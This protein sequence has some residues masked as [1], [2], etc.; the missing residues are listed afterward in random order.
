MSSCFRERDT[1]SK[2]SEMTS[3]SPPAAAQLGRFYLCVAAW[4]LAELPAG[5]AAVEPSAG[6]WPRLVMFYIVAPADVFD[7]LGGRWRN[8]R[9]FT[10]FACD[11]TF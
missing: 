5:E 2:G 10:A 11:A 8:A 7:G 1:A 3:V 6:L 9:H 4:L